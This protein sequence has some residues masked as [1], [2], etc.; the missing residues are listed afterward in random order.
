VY[1]VFIDRQDFPSNNLDA[2]WRRIIVMA[3]FGNHLKMHLPHGLRD[4]AREF[5]A[6]V[7]GCKALEAQPYPD[8]DLY[9]FDGGAV[10]G[11]FFCDDKDVLAVSDYEKATWLEIKVADPDGTRKQLETFGVEVVDFAAKTRFYFKAPGGQVY[12]LAPL[13]GEL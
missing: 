8:L 12:R 13:D 7:L 9:E 10:V 4:R 1:R 3:V 6:G 5:Y 11:L 2:V